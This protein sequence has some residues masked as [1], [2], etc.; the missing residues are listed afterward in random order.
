MCSC[1]CGGGG[2]Y[3]L[4]RLGEIHEYTMMKYK[5]ESIYNI[6]INLFPENNCILTSNQNVKIIKKY[7]IKYT[8]EFF[9]N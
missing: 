7:K 6:F 4:M 3:S 5:S 8:M 1:D 9:F 2:L